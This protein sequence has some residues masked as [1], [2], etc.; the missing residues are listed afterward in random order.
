MLGI[1]VDEIQRVKP[2]RTA[3]ITNIYPLLDLN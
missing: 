2:N 1:T 3:W